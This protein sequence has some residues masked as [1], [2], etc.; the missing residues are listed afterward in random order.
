MQFIRFFF[1]SN[2][3]M[4]I[5]LCF[6]WEFFLLLLLMLL[7]IT[8]NLTI[9]KKLHYGPPGHMAECASPNFLKVRGGKM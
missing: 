3:M 7:F 8:I 5:K 4:L 6:E 1:L 9:G 2:V